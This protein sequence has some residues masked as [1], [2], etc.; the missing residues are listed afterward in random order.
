MSIELTQEQTE[1]FR[2]KLQG[3]FDEL[4][5]GVQE[6][7]LRSDSEHFADVAGEVHDE[8]EA[9][10]ASVLVDLDLAAI[11]RHASTIPYDLLCGIT[12]RVKRIEIER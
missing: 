1:H 6:E 11:A 2:H 8:E 9:S 12:Q 4:R 7:V 3:R 5:Q 10:A